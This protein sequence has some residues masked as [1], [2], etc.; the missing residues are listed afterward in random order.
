[1]AANSHKQPLLQL[2]RD[3]HEDQAVHLLQ[4][5]RIQAL[6]DLWLVVQSLRSPIG[7]GPLGLF[8]LFLITLN[9]SVLS[10]ALPKDSMSSLCFAMG[11]SDTGWRLSG[12]RHARFLFASKQA[13]RNSINSINRDWLSGKRWV[14]FL[15]EW[16][17]KQSQ[18][19]GIR[20]ELT[21][22]IH[23]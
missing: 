10:P 17:Y 3:P 13:S 23:C 19:R 7:L 14:Y 22:L 20:D 4:M 8:V 1:M 11:P 6:Q 16:T 9:C 21:M 5:C 12:D 15:G 18:N 2:L